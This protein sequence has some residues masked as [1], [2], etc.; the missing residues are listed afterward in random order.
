MVQEPKRIELTRE[1]LYEKLWK[2]PTKHVAEEFGMSDVML[3][4]VCKEYRIPKPYVGYW[5]KK[6]HGKNPCPSRKLHP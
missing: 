1:E 3:G 6:E 5:A 2:T 4:K